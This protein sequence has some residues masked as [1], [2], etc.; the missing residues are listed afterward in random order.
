MSVSNLRSFGVWQMCLVSVSSFRSLVF[1]TWFWS[2]S[3]IFVVLVFGSCF[4]CFSI[5]FDGA[6]Q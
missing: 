5:V 2:L 4:W 3:V 6:C 1:D